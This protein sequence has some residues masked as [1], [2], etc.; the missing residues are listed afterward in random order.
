VT[1]A[2]VIWWGSRRQQDHG[3][4]AVLLYFHATLLLRPILVEPARFRA[5]L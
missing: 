2:R 5:L 3:L 4:T 1:I